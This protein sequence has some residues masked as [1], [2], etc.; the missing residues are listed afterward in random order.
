MP[1]FHQ[2]EEK[3]VFLCVVQQPKVVGCSPGVKALTIRCYTMTPVYVLAVEVA[4]IQSRVFFFALGVR[5]F[6]E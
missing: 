4:S 5:V 6:C 1:T 3:L 2:R